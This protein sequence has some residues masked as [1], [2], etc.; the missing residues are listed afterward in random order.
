MDKS[1]LY[2]KVRAVLI[3]I[4]DNVT[5]DELNY[6][7]IAVLLQKRDGNRSHTAKELKISL[8]TLRIRISEMI[9]FKYPVTPARRGVP[10]HK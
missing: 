4:P 9:Y 2:E 8:R 1:D 10:H 3:G 7:F 6:N 5:L